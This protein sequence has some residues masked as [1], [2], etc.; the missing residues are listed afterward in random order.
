MENAKEKRG[1][2]RS[3]ETYIILCSVTTIETWKE[4]YSKHTKCCKNIQENVKKRRREKVVNIHTRGE[5]ITVIKVINISII[6][7]RFMYFL[8]EST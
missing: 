7:H 2:N 1:N 8:G 4:F 5:M 6:S 3:Q